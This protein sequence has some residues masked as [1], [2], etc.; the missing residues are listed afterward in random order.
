[1]PATDA[2][3]DD[4]STAHSEH[5]FIRVRP[6]ATA[7]NPRTVTKQ[8]QR[9]HG[10]GPDTT[11]SLISRLVRR[12]PDPTTI[13]FRLVSD[14]TTETTIDYYVGIDSESV[15]V[16]ER[17]L[18]GMFPNTYELT[19]VTVDTLRVDE[20]PD[21]AVEFLSNLERRRDWQTQ[22]TAFE[23]FHETDHT[24]LPLSDVIET[25]ATSSVPIVF[26]T[27]VQ[28]KPD[29]SRQAEDRRIDIEAG[30]D[31]FGGALSNAIW[32]PPPKDEHILSAS[33]EARLDEL[34]AR[35]TRRSFEVNARAVTLEAD[36]D[37]STSIR[38]LA[39][40][41]DS[42]SHT[43]Y[44]ISSAVYTD[45]DV[46]RVYEDIHTQRFYAADFDR[47]TNRLPWGKH[48][49]RGIVADAREAPNFCIL[50][51][52]SLTSAGK[53]A[54]APTP[55]ERTSIPRPPAAQLRAY[56]D[57]L[58]VGH[59]LTQ[60]GTASA[61]G[62]SLPP[63]LQPLH[64]AWFGKTGSGKSTALV[65]A[66]L[67]NQEATEGANILID[68]KG[69][70]MGEA[71]CRAHFAKYGTLDNVL[72][73]DCA[74]V[75]PAF[76][77]FDIRDELDAGVARTTAVED[78]VDHYIEILTQ[79]MGKQ[80]FEQAVR[81]P[82][83]IR[84]L[85]K[86]LFD[87]VN[88]DDAFSHRELHD[89]ARRMHERQTAPAV[90]DDELERMLGGVVANRARSFDEIMQGVANRI[91]KI[92]V[93]KRLAR[94]FNHVADRDG[95]ETKGPH[96]DLADSLDE[97]AVIIFDTGGLRSGAQRVLTL[98]I[99]SNLWTALRRR[100]Q[101]GEEDD[102]PLVN[103]YIEEAASVAVTDLLTEFLAKSRSFGC[104]VTLAM[105]FPGQLREASER[106]YNE[107]L[108]NV[109][110]FVTGNVPID[111]ELAARLATDEMD[112]TEVGNRL[113]ALRRGQWFV[114][115]PA[116][117]D[118]AEPRPFLVRS[119]PLPPGDPAGARPLTESE[120][121]RF[122]ETM[123]EL[124]KRT[125]DEM[126]V[127]LHTSSEADEN[128]D[129]PTPSL[130]V[131]TALAHTKRMPETV[132]YDG[133]IHA[134]R[135][136]NCD[137]RYDRSIGGMKR[138]I[139]CCSSL[140]AVDRDDIPVCSVGLK[141]TEEERELSDW[142]DP[143][144]LFL[145]VV[146]NAQRLRYD[147]LEYDILRDSMIRLQEY[148][149]IESGAIQ[150]L[151]DGDLLRHDTD[152]PHRL[153]TVTPEG[154]KEIGESYRQG[155][156][157]GHGKGDLE[158]SSQHIVAVEIL[159]QYIVTE[160][161]ENPESEVVE[162]V[163]YYEIREGELPAAGFMGG[164]DDAAAATDGFEQHRLDCVGLDAE[165]DVVVAG[166]A[167]RINHDYRKAVPEDFDKMAACEP[168]ESI[169]VV[170]SQSDGHK[171]LSALNN[172]NG[173]EPRVEK[174]YAETTP[175]QHFNIDTPGL[176]A[177]YPAAWLRDR[178]LER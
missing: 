90:S 147:E 94:M 42:V 91:E 25:M 46:D 113:R 48:T 104:S 80:R 127:T 26:Q 55:G 27:L 71:Y 140:D 62:L 64:V 169:W 74:E 14:G 49:G 139:A 134:L 34:A 123:A 43:C 124:S 32:G 77:F 18:N 92:P 121:V 1:M 24:R 149:G 136:V 141:L 148:V 10:L 135:C 37:Q 116:A 15:D 133:E 69:D 16:L 63:S 128:G 56:T 164:S 117:F 165:G 158:E 35:L 111:R 30:L 40:A 112:A 172:S 110:T 177:M 61:R 58:L 6:T 122:E 31:T 33:D 45:D 93:D 120:Q 83:I 36:T 73:F 19:R 132:E 5:S 154:R 145:Q 75:L 9:L 125:R 29:W 168:A 146:Y 142:T 68:P 143:Q 39:T 173:G 82:D 106:A 157:Y 3:P 53:R 67:E 118:T 153:F 66:I 65:N 126:G 23:Q 41:F 131:D 102:H 81:S 150:D 88:G 129:E 137:N 4:R 86:A 114:K 101:K 72:Y 79:I 162:V 156:D 21:A 99:L 109:S 60:D 22:L 167:E 59:P 98:V 166:E 95:E 87:P 85:V 144:L 174:T 78:T 105:Q 17:I 160:F 171:V 155:V 50:T 8:F 119:A 70:G 178:Y 11:T 44:E 13:E 89:A 2:P 47:L 76:S 138:A 152:H 38:E 103:L 151:L 161:A 115:L 7:P 84:Y 100:T 28:P 57:G 130:R 12:T 170:M 54:V 163:P 97:N 175:P 20:T 52:E 159:R 176:T 107:V 96:F 108:N 51:G